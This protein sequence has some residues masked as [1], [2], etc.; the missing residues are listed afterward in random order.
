MFGKP[1]GAKFSNRLFRTLKS[2]SLAACTAVLMTFASA[3]PSKADA[4]VNTNQA[5]IENLLREQKLD[6]TDALA[7]FEFVLSALPDRAKIYPTENYYYFTF[8]HGGLVY[9]GNLRLDASDRDQGF[10]HFAYSPEHVFWREPEIPT[11]RKLGAADGV[12]VERVSPLTY[13]VA[14]RGRTVRFEINDLSGVRPPA[15]VVAPG[16]TYIGPVFD[17]SGIQFYL[18]FNPAEKVFLYVLNEQAPVPEVFDAT[19]ISPRITIG[20]RTSYAFYADDRLPR[21]ILIGVYEGNTILNNIYDGPFDQLPDNTLEGDVLKNAILSILPDYANKIDRFGSMADGSER[22][23]ISPYL[24]YETEDDF[25]IILDCLKDPKRQ[26]E[27]Y[28]GCFE[29]TALVSAD[30]ATQP[31]EPA[32]SQGAPQRK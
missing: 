20:R 9:G 22:Y 19:K 32:P 4:S 25:S 26:Q 7:V 28:Y 1:N 24:Y 23:A 27:A 21:K 29:T 5:F 12:R 10:V 15:N 11:Y 30:N 3:G 13:D 14:F 31:A 17:E 2:I 18:M 8:H 16:E 6:I